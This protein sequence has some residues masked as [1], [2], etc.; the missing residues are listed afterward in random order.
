MFDSSHD[1][2]HTAHSGRDNFEQAALSPDLTPF[3]SYFAACEMEKEFPQYGPAPINAAFHRS[4]RDSIFARMPDNSLLLVGGEIEGHQLFRQSADFHYLTGFDA[5]GAYCLLMKV[6]GVQET[7]MLVTERD[8]KKTLWDG[9]VP[10]TGDAETIYGVDR[11]IALQNSS[12]KELLPEFLDGVKTVFIS[13]PAAATAGEKHSSGKA[14]DEALESANFQG[15]VVEANGILHSERL[16]KES[17][18]IAL[19]MRASKITARAHTEVMR[20]RGLTVAEKLANVVPNEG[21]I[22]ADLE[23][24]FRRYG[25]V[26]P[27]FT[28]IVGAD[29]NACILHYICNDKQCEK[30]SLVLVDGGAEYSGY[31]GD[32]TRTW[33]VSG[34]FTPEQKEIYQ[35]VLD[36]QKA[37]INAVKTG[38]TQGEVH[39][40]ALDTISNQL[41]EKGILPE[42][43]AKQ[44]AKLFPHG[45]GHFLGLDVHDVSAPGNPRDIVLQPGMVITI[46]PG[47]YLSAAL[48]KELGI[49]PRYASIGVRI[50]DDVLVSPAG[51]IVLTSDVPKEVSDIE[52]LM[53][54]S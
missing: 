18:E 34:K 8:S 32:I 43:H 54:G 27:S 5:P 6:N 7:V 22:Q 42:E 31:A 49:D 50:E 51:A 12:L 4:I 11:A 21:Q 16:V 26:R 37:A 20:T 44:V 10:S 35:I 25:A 53:A 14:I 38:V 28:T 24:G 40:V 33:P 41:L 29:E 36:A 15:E 9:A 2:R 30:N 13:A 48:V 47:L 19:L 39:K 45:T 52:R 23:R 46:E 17:Y 3:R 1:Q